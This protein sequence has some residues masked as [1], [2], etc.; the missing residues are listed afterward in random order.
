MVPLS[1]DC[2]S[3]LSCDGLISSLKGKTKWRWELSLFTGVVLCCDVVVVVVVSCRVVSCCVV[4]CC[5]ML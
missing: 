2:L 4:S 5:V 3:L 1:Y